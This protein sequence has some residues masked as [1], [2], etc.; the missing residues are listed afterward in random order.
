[1]HELSLATDIIRAASVELSRMNA[2]CARRIRVRVGELSGM[3][4]DNLRFCLE[5]L[6]DGTPLGAAEI[7]VECVKA[8]LLCPA[9]GEVERSGR[10][11]LLCS[12]CGGSISGFVGG[13]EIDVALECEEVEKE[14]SHAD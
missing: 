2:T 1:M 11:G 4:P 9:C 10:F 8:K 6:R 12:G 13:R 7:D 14:Q 5:V 3:N